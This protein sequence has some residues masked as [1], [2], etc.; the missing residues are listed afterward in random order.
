M[1]I[2]SRPPRAPAGAPGRSTAKSA[3][4]RRSCSTRSGTRGGAGA[5]RIAGPGHARARALLRD[6]RWDV[7]G[8]GPVPL[9]GQPELPATLG[10][11]LWLR[12]RRTVRV[13]GSR[14]AGAAAGGALARPSS[15]ESLGGLLLRFGPGSRAADTV[16]VILGLVGLAVGGL[17]AA[18]VGGGPG[19]GRGPRPLVPGGG[20]RPLRRPG[21][22]RGRRGRAPG[23]AVDDPGPLRAR[24]V[25]D[26]AAASRGWCWAAP[27][28]SAM[29]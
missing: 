9:L 16:P 19:R 14:W 1:R 6:T 23:R 11:L 17:G 7:A 5:A 12:V 8:S 2:P 13:A 20:P 25:A 4:R 18:G 21:R 10:A 29:R 3:A 22:R 15:A 28:A 24:P 27:P 26:R